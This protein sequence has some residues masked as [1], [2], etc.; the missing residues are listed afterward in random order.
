MFTS[1]VVRMAGA[2]SC[3]CA[4]AGAGISAGGP[5]LVPLAVAQGPLNEHLWALLARLQR[6]LKLEG[7]GW[8]VN[9]SYCLRVTPAF[10]RMPGGKGV[11]CALLQCARRQLRRV[12]GQPAAEASSTGP[13]S[14]TFCGVISG[15][16]TTPLTG[17]IAM[18]AIPLS[19]RRWAEKGEKR[20]YSAMPQI[21]HRIAQHA[22]PPPH[23]R[24][25]QEAWIEVWIGSSTSIGT[26]T[27]KK[28]TGTRTRASTATSSSSGTDT[29]AGPCT[30]TSTGTSSSDH[31]KD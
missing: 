22:H 2:G 1:L 3:A 17:P 20:E 24:H 14:P 28:S 4:S 21:T 19:T 8:G 6:Q 11:G 29:G 26:S 13:L 12:Q 15:A 9:D 30:N 18:N 10:K 16:S 25:V 23:P 7:C 31:T 5:W 27:S